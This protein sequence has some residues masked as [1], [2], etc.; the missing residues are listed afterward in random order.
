MDIRDINEKRGNLIKS[1][2]EN[3]LIPRNQI[4]AMSGLTNTYIL[5]LM[6][7]KINNVNRYKLIAFAISANLNVP[8]IDEMLT[9]FDRAVLNKD[10]IG[11]ILKS[12]KKIKFSSTIHPL[13]EE[14]SYEFMVYAAELFPAPTVFNLIHPTASLWVEGHR[15]YLGKDQNQGHALYSKIREAIGLERKNSFTNNLS[16][17]VTEHFIYKGDLENYLLK[18]TDGQEMYY[19]IKH[20]EQILLYLDRYPNF[21]FYITN[22]YHAFSFLLK[23][24]LEP[25][26]KSGLVLFTGRE[27]DSIIG[28]MAGHLSAFS[29]RNQLIVQNFIADIEPLKKGIIEELLDCKKLIS[30][31]EDLIDRAKSISSSFR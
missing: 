23:E 16:K 2:I 9:V 10:D 28:K 6:Q 26:E 7:G 21:K 18:C 22:V 29:T 31:F 8:E 4:A 3:S 1:A 25:K 15:T 27:Y 20:L 5:D 12:A 13:R 14:L 17:Y 30:Y 19:R 24:Q 11:T